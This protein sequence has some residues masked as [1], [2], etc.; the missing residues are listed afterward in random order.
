MS[1]H[2]DET[3]DH[4]HTMRVPR[5]RGAL[6]GLLLL[7]LGVWGA[8]IP[9][10][11][12]YFNYEYQSDQTWVWT[13]AR[14]WLE[15]LPG[16]VTAVGGLLLI[17]AANRILGSLAGWLAAVGGA[18]FIVGQ[19]LS[20]ILHIGSVGTPN[21][22]SN[23]DRALESL[24]FFY[25][26]GAVILFL[27]AFA[28]GR[29]AVVGVRDVR[30]VHKDERRRAEA[31]EQAADQRAAEQRAADQRVAHDNAVP[32]KAAQESVVDRGAAGDRATEATATRERADHTGATAAG[33]YASAPPRR[34][35]D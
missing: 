28:L 27:S 35:S 25:G 32:D 17:L 10:I 13:A 8:V 15:V 20:Q 26:L 18:W 34:E 4:V 23:G 19:S 5:S 7:I 14:F 6:T 31:A 2:N 9:F 29:L 24:G 33:D 21:S 11:G 30:A 12:P 16:A 3:L 22:T 1:S